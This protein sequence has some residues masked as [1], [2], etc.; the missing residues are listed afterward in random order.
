MTRG[1]GSRLTAGSIVAVVG[2]VLVGVVLVW[3]GL[4]N[5]NHTGATPQV[6]SSPSDGK[7]L[8]SASP[9]PSE[10]DEHEEPEGGIT[11]NPDDCS[12]HMTAEQYRHFGERL[13]KFE[14]VNQM[15]A[16]DERI[17]L[18]LPYVTQAFMDT[19][20]GFYPGPVVSD[21]SV[22]ELDPSSAM[23][24]TMSYN[25]TLVAQVVPVVSVVIYESDGTR[26]IVQEPVIMPPDI[27]Q[28]VLVDNKWFVNQQ[29]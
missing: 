26:T 29:Q 2:L 17:E 18:M 20:R 4:Q 22:I 5:W 19:Q 7:A 3:F 25:N 14:L 8:S 16:S 27:T 6:T 15:P 1:S 13:L 9:S 11:E 21:G 24:C 12:N 10:E 28:W 23:R